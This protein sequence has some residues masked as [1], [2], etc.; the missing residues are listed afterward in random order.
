MVSLFGWSVDTYKR[1]LFLQL[2]QNIETNV[3]TVY[4]LDVLTDTRWTRAELNRCLCL[5]T[6]KAL[7]EILKKERE[8]FTVKKGFNWGR[9]CRIV[10]LRCFEY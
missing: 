8:G 4:I 9:D 2:S 10:I 7:S 5:V 6:E 3:K 1:R